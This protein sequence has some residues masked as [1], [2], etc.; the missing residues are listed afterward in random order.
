M[1]PV[2]ELRDNFRY[3]PETGKITSAKDTGCKKQWKAGRVV[4]TISDEG[5]LT[6]SLSRK[7]Y[8]AHRVAWALTTGSWPSLELDHINGV[9]DDNRWCNLREAM[10]HQNM[11]NGKKPRSNKSGYKGVLR[12]SKSSWS[13]AIR[14]RGRSHYLGSFGCPT[15]A[16]IARVARLKE[17]HGE[18]AR[19]A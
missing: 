2:S 11:A 13:A 17:L 19:A 8:K 1:I 5:Y 18:F 3:D 4:G 10:H 14:V 7:N 9:K 12:I 6:V 16:F 15:A